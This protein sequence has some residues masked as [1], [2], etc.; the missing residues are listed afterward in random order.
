[1][2]YLRRL[3]SIFLAYL[4]KLLRTRYVLKQ[5]KIAHAQEVV[6]TPVQFLPVVL[7]RQDA[8]LRAIRAGNLNIHGKDDITDRK[9]WQWP[10]LPSSVRRL[11]VP[12]MKLTPY[13]LRRMSRTPVPRRAMNMIKGAMISLNWDVRPIDGIE[14]KD[15]KAQTERIKIAKQTFK[16]PNND[17]SFQSFLEQ[18]L[19][20]YLILGGFV[21]ELGLTVDPQRP[22]KMWPVNIESIRLM[23]AWQ[24]ST[25]DMP[26]YVQMTGLKGE[27]GALAFYD[28]EMI[29][30]KDNP[31]TDNPFGLGKMEVG[32]Q[33]VNDFLGVQGMSGRAGTDQVHKC[34]PEGTEVLTRRGWILWRDARKTDEYATRSLDGRLQWQRAIAFVREQHDG[35]LIQFSNRELQITVTPNHRMYGWQFHKDGGKKVSD[36]LGFVE[37]VELYNAVTERPGSGWRGHSK[38]SSVLTDFRIPTRAVWQDGVL[39]S[40]KIRIG[41][42]TFRWKDW[43][44]FL[45]IWI[46]EGSCMATVATLT[47]ARKP[48]HGDYRV[49]IAQSKSA[50]R[51]KYREITS[52]L[53]R[54]GICCQRKAD[55]FIFV[56]RDIW[57]YLSDLGCSHTKF[58]PQWVKDAPASVIRIFVAWAMKGDGT[59]GPHG[60]R[61]Y[62]TVSKQ[63][64]DDMQELFQKIGS[65]AAVRPYQDGDSLMYAVEEMLRDAISIVPEGGRGK[66]RMPKRIPYSGLVYCAMVPN[67]TLY[68]RE[69][70]YAFWSGNTWL[71]W[72][73]AQPESMIQIVRRH[74]QNDLEGQAKISL[75]GGGK[76]P[77]ILEVTPVTID[78]LL[79]PWQEM[80][81]RMIANAFDMSA[82]ALGIEHD[83]N[84]AVGEVL[85]DKDFRTAV[86][87]TARRIQEGF[88]RRI[89]HDKLRWHDLEFV[90]TNLDDPDLQTMMD[91]C[92]SLYQMNA[93]TP[94][95]VLKKLNLPKL[96]GPFGDLTQAEQMIE[97]S[98]VQVLSQ[99]QLADSAMQRQQQMMDQMPQPMGPD[100]QQQ[101]QIPAGG[102][103]GAGKPGG[104]GGNA[105]STGYGQ[106]QSPKPLTLPKFPIQGVA[107]TAKQ[108]ARMP[109]N[110]VQDV[111]LNSGVKPSQIVRQMDEQEPGILQQLADEVREFI[112]QQLKE[113]EKAG[114][115]RVSR[116]QWKKWEK[117]LRQ[118]V[119]RDNKRTNDLAE[120]MRK[121]GGTTL[122]RPGTSSGRPGTGGPTRT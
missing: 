116:G 109:V 11:Q 34:F 22:L 29:Y 46:A 6:K 86:V 47:G 63:L 89:L 121:S 62:Y 85:S 84:R 72:E 30:L 101:P 27:R 67:G 33:S 59:V 81:I 115:T 36:E 53:R 110:Q 77:D 94:N 105:G 122:G 58:V 24:E 96:V 88:T 28:D 117:E 120:W 92:R 80:L 19:E 118:S 114:L 54:M 15:K 104:G 16:H 2:P 7:A 45:G 32:F 55:R 76:K 17:D 91:M 97:M 68:C 71:W 40:A 38:T 102:G 113:E 75:I 87:P 35:D 119:R 82:M 41:E 25:P 99:N 48:V 111:F 5:F 20:D 103:G 21:A 83:I 4:V 26:R 95:T 70:G 108:V 23:P 18:G 79:I 112:Q 31:S 106:P 12:I 52:L 10:F 8:E 3:H 51:T 60:K 9:S 50:N 61:I 78:D 98:R 13:N 93:I 100:G 69:N 37:A 44:A 107:A 66:A 43:A 56:D 73:T 90:F 64:A 49:Q 14:V 39:P 65:S 42:R 74:I 57:A 1:M